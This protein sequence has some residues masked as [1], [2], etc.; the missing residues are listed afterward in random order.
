MNMV[1]QVVVEDLMNSDLMAPTLV[2]EAE[3]VQDVMKIP[4]ITDLMAAAWDQEDLLLVEV[5]PEADLMSQ[6]IGVAGIM[7]IPQILM[8]HTEAIAGIAIMM[9]MIIAGIQEI[10]MIERA[11]GNHLKNVE[12]K[13]A[14]IS[15]LLMFL[16]KNPPFYLGGSFLNIFTRYFKP[17][18]LL[19]I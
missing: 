1:D 4:M 5:H 9:R 13:R 10:L 15:R 14:V 17:L 2:T 6:T 16:F 12:A 7:R 3:A 11:I 19:D 18:N 8:T